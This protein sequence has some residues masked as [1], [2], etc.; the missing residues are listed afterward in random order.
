[1]ADRGR[2]KAHGARNHDRAGA[3]VDDDLG[4]AFGGRDVEHL[5]IR[6]QPGAGIRSGRHGERQRDAVLDPRHAG[7]GGVD[8]VAHAGHGHEIGLEQIPAQHFAE[9]EIAGDGGFDGRPIGDAA[10]GGHVHGQLG[11]VLSGHAQTADCEIALRHGID[12]P[13]RPVERGHDQRPAAQGLGLTHGGH[14]HV[15]ALAGLGEGGKLGRD[16]DGGRVL[17][18]GIDAGRQLQPQSP[19]NAPHG[20]CQIGEIV[21]AR[22]VEADH[23]AVTGQLV[24]TDRVELAE[25]A[26]AFRHGGNRHHRR[27]GGEDE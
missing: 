1:M 8:R 7:I 2:G 18:R 17:E 22:P 19:G 4:G 25:V 23:D 3:A 14:G 12:L 27:D 20:L 9:V 10:H 11:P 6:H 5:D 15:D 21:I 13:V 24:R 16:D 26:N